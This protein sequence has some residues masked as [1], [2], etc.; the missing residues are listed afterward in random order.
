MHYVV[1]A[2]EHSRQRAAGAAPRAAARRPVG[3]AG[4]RWLMFAAALVGCLTSALVVRASSVAAFT[5]TT[6]SPGNSWAAS[7]PACTPAQLL[8]NPGFESGRTAWT[9]TSTGGTNPISNSGSEAARTGTWKAWLNGY[10]TTNTDVVYQQVTIPAACAA[11]Y[12]FYLHV[13][14][15]E[16][17]CSVYDTLAVQVRNSAN[18]STLATLAT[19]DN[20]DAASG[21]SKKTFSLNGYAGQTVT[22]RFLGN[23]DNSNKTSF[24]IDDTGVATS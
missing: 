4:A 2:D 14:T 19:Y 7:W 24:V 13:T 21:F 6:Q 16:S 5:G 15:N 11:S 20:T 1:R 10:A 3:L 18:S 12:T 23:E 9:D 8:S 17:C 22:L